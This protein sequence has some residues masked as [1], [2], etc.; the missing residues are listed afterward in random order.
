[1]PTIK[2]N[3]GDTLIISGRSGMKYIDKNGKEYYVG[4]EMLSF[5]GEYDF[6]VYSNLI[7]YYN[8]Y[9]KEYNPNNIELYEEYDEEKGY[10]TGKIK[11]KERFDSNISIEEMEFILKRVVELSIQGNIKIEIG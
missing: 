1:M 8:D 2:G 9:E 3:I 4:S 6:V 5:G 7:K 10:G 11:F